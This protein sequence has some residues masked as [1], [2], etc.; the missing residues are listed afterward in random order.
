MYLKWE[1][2]APLLKLLKFKIKITNLLFFCMM[3]IQSIFYTYL[4]E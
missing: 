2:H 1:L 3:K 4:S